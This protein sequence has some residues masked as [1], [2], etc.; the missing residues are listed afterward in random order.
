MYILPGFT[1]RGIETSPVLNNL[2]LTEY[3]YLV[4]VCNVGYHKN[5]LISTLFQFC[6]VALTF[7]IVI[8]TNLFKP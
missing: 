3:S 7:K 8:N 2:K 5:S 4:I 6:I 1:A